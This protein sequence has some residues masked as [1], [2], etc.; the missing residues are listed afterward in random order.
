MHGDKMIKRIDENVQK[1]SLP[2]LFYESFSFCTWHRHFLWHYS[3]IQNL[4][5]KPYLHPDVSGREIRIM[6]MKMG[7]REKINKRCL[8]YD[9]KEG[10]KREEYRNLMNNKKCK[11]WCSYGIRQWRC[12]CDNNGKGEA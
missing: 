12:S 7:K 1:L 10:G 9:D 3:T 11:R 5:W 2:S 4:I 8:W 6:N